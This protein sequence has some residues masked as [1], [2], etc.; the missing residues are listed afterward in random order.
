MIIIYIIVLMCEIML[1]SQSIY[2]SNIHSTEYCSW[3]QLACPL[4]LTLKLFHLSVCYSCVTP[5]FSFQ[6]NIEVP[7]LTNNDHSSII[8]NGPIAV[9]NTHIILKHAVS[10]SV[11]HLV[12]R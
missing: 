7:D 11:L 10:H 12:D 4:L 9:K 5:P 3:C 8:C 1:I 6:W 2:I